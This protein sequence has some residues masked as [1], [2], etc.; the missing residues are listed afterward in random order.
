MTSN[1]LLSFL[2]AGSLLGH[3]VPAQCMNLSDMAW[4][5]TASGGLASIIDY[6]QLQNAITKYKQ[7][8]NNASQKELADLLRSR[9]GRT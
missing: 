9:V 7:R 6:A 5:V 2:L 3:T 4:I 1:K 8:T